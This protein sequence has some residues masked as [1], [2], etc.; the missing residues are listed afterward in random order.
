[1]TQPANVSSIR[2]NHYRGANQAAPPTPDLVAA[3]ETV[4]RPSDPYEWLE[5]IRAHAI[6]MMSQAYEKSS[7]EW[8]TEM[9]KVTLFLDR[10]TVDYRDLPPG[11]AGRTHVGS[12]WFLV[13][14]GFYWT[15]WGEGDVE[16]PQ[17]AF[18]NL[19]AVMIHEATHNSGIKN[20]CLT[21]TV[22]DYVLKTLGKEMRVG[23]H[24][25]WD[26][27]NPPQRTPQ[28][29]GF[30]RTENPE[31]TFSPHQG[32][33]AFD[34]N[35]LPTKQQAIAGAQVNLTAARAKKMRGWQA[36]PVNSMEYGAGA[37]TGFVNLGGRPMEMGALVQVGGANISSGGQSNP[38]ST[39]VQVGALNVAKE[40]GAAK[41][42]SVVQVGIVNYSKPSDETT[43]LSDFT[44]GVMPL[45]NVCWSP[46][47]RK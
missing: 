32:E 27:T 24:C 11:M 6:D 28:D 41:L 37:Q 4:K 30:V 25:G 19:A 1:M 17:S 45:V 14:T 34:I 47:G 15:D 8:K 42:T 33:R 2:T 38:M 22:P 20:E 10:A 40:R 44:G 9:N 16:I 36:A 3:E 29:T 35:V 23:Y 43:C 26:L 5:A 31:S 18:D 46:L 12:D 39:L 13:D 7:P 21:D